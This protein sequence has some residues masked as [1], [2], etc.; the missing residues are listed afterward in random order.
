[1]PILLLFQQYQDIADILKNKSFY[2]NRHFLPFGQADPTY[3]NLTTPA[4]L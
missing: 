3:P 1:M 2:I 4:S